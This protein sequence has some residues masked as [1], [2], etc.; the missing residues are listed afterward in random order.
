MQLVFLEIFSSKKTP[1]GSTIQIMSRF[2]DYSSQH[3]RTTAHLG[4]HSQ[5]LFYGPPKPRSSKILTTGTRS[6]AL[7]NV[8]SIRCPAHSKHGSWD[9]EIILAERPLLV[10][11]YVLSAMFTRRISAFGTNILDDLEKRTAAEVEKHVEMAVGRMVEEDQAAFKSLCN[12]KDTAPPLSGIVWTNGLMLDFTCAQRNAASHGKYPPSEESSYMDRYRGIFRSISRINHSC[13]SNIV[14]VFNLSSFSL[15]IVAMSNIKAGEQILRSYCD[16]GMS[17]AQR[18]AALTG[19]G[20]QCTCSACAN[21]TPES[22]KLRSEYRERAAGYL[23]DETFNQL[24]NGELDCT[25]PENR[26]RAL[27]VLEPMLKFHQESVDEGLSSA[28]E[29]GILSSYVCQ[30]YLKLGMHEEMKAYVG[31]CLKFANVALNQS[32]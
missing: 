24:L 23:N 12:V 13:C 25:L 4:C 6:K 19:N 10:T 11:P 21:A 14:E 8:T 16:H 5:C 9:V 30:L 7:C 18:Q 3:R 20:F 27:E 32:Y 1:S 22:D 28:F 31:H 29:L 26:E 17:K 2:D 15:Q